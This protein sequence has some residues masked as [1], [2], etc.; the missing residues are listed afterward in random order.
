MGNLW[1]WF[2]GLF[3]TAWFKAFLMFAVDKLRNILEV[4]GQEAYEKIKAKIIEVSK[5]DIT[6][7]AKVDL[8]FKFI[9]SL[10]PV[11]SDS[12]V[13]YM[14]EAIVQELKDKKVI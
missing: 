6:N 7:K 9:K 3:K 4:I 13:N 2:L 11:L 12:A 5:M 1:K 10:V 8:V 14:I